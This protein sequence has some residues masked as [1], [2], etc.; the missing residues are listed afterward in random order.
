MQRGRSKT[1]E[2]VVIGLVLVERVP[3][4]RRVTSARLPTQLMGL[5]SPT[6]TLYMLRCLITK[7]QILTRP[8][9]FY[10][11]LFYAFIYSH[12]TNSNVE[13]IDLCL[14]ISLHEDLKKSIYFVSRDNVANVANVVDRRGLIARWEKSHPSIK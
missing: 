7:H 4:Y 11:I 13:F 9:D 8:I 10:F 1:V 12:L 3:R 14:L 6:P 5:S 2:C